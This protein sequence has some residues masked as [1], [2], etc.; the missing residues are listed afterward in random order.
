[1][2]EDNKVTG[3]GYPMAKARKEAEGNLGWK[4]WAGMATPD[5]Q[6]SPRLT[7]TFD[8]DSILPPLPRILEMYNSQLLNTNM[9]IAALKPSIKATPSS[10]AISPKEKAPVLFAPEGEPLVAPTELGMS[11]SIIA[12]NES[13]NDAAREAQGI[14]ND[15]IVSQS[16]RIATQDEAPVVNQSQGLMSRPALE[17]KVTIT[18]DNTLNIDVLYKGLSDSQKD[19]VDSLLNSLDNNG[20]SGVEKVAFIA[21]AK[22]E[23]G[24]FNTLVESGGSAGDAYFV[25]KYWANE[26][27]RNNLG[28][29]SKQD[30]IDFK[31]RGPLQLTGKWNYQHVNKLLKEVGID[32]DIVKNPDL[33]ETNKEIGDLTS[34]LYWKD[35]VVKRKGITDFT[36]VDKV[37]SGINPGEDRETKDIR[38][39][40]FKELYRE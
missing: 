6:K 10:S 34:I 19:N 35:R 11:P 12:R 3:L 21:Q 16:D 14:L 31:G 36:D 22:R 17:P 27:V 23:S 13:T 38:K 33:L 28:N 39:G 37:T 25:K 32:V 24:N 26:S 18:A 9:D 30:A 20:I 2:V 1:M 40:F 4:A 15:R 29:E 7:P 8:L 5:Y